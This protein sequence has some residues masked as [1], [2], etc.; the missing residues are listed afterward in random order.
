M[1]IMRRDGPATRRSDGHVN[2]TGGRRV[3][4]SRSPTARPVARRTS[5]ACWA[6]HPVVRSVVGLNMRITATAALAGAPLPATA[7][8][9]SAV[10]SD[11]GV[12]VSTGQDVSGFT[13]GRLD[14]GAA[15]GGDGEEAAAAMGALD[16]G[17]Q[18]P[19]AGSG[20]QGQALARGLI[21]V[22]IR[23][24]R[25][26]CAVK[27]TC[28]GGRAPASRG[29]MG[30]AGTRRPGAQWGGALRPCGAS[31]TQ[32]RLLGARPRSERDEERDGRPVGRGGTAGR[33]PS[34]GRARSWAMVGSARVA[35]GLRARS[36]RPPDAVTGVRGP[37]DGTPRRMPGRP[38]R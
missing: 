13:G 16:G 26:R 10:L 37:R 17:V 25:V 9:A 24:P 6:A 18:E 7:A 27:G 12:L 21:V 29:Q 5:V 8:A 20:G 22:P 28:A 14:G 35:G 3:R 19:G 32:P 30:A 1:V 4:P 11:G 34:A 2:G 15:W 33:F 23:V 31:L 38:P 36:G